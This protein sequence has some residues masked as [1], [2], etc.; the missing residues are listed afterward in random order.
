MFRFLLK[1][2][3]CADHLLP[4]EYLLRDISMTEFPYKDKEFIKSRLKD[5]EF[6]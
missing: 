5:L 2:L 4:V 1:R 3:D 6:I